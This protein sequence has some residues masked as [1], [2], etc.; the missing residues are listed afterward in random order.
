MSIENP[1]SEEE[2]FEEASKMKEK[3]EKEK[4]ESGKDISYDTAEQEVAFEEA[5]KMKEKI[6]AGE[7]TSYEE[8]KK[9]IDQSRIR[10]QTKQEKTKEEKSKEKL[11]ENFPEK[12]REILKRS[13]IIDSLKGLSYRLKSREGERLSPLV[14]PE[15]IDHLKGAT[16]ALE[17]AISQHK[18][19]L[20]QIGD[21]FARI[22]TVFDSML[23]SPRITNINDDPEN[24][25]IV[26]NKLRSIYDD[27]RELANQLNALE[28]SE[29]QDG[30]YTF[31][32]D[33]YKIAELVDS[34][35]IQIYHRLDNLENYRY[36]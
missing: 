21:I 31:T 12:V 36:R 24:L 17:D 11:S 14:Y 26:I 34:K 19:D 18:F 27:S 16:L 9:L 5:S 33:L 10:E 20:Q 25:R 8:A 32:H 23:N 15:D 29:H 28:K 6:E 1:Y 7:A 30:N 13:S 22:R 4:I 2:A 35:N 3:I